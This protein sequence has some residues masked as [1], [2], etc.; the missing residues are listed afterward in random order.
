MSREKPGTDCKRFLGVHKRIPKDVRR[1]CGICRQHG[2]IVETRGH[3]CP[4]R[5][6]TCEKCSLIRERRL[7]MSTQIRLRR[8]QDRCFQRTEDAQSADLILDTQTIKTM[9]TCYVCQKC[10]NHGILKWKKDHKK[11]CVYSDCPCSQCQLIDTR[12]ALDRTIKGEK[13]A[14]RS[15]ENVS[16]K[17]LKIDENKNIESTSANLLTIPDVGELCKKIA[18]LEDTSYMKDLNTNY[19]KIPSF[20]QCNLPIHFPICSYSFSFDSPSNK[21]K[22][23]SFSIDSL[24]GN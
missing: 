24:L 22:R 21:T 9:N 19:A 2:S 18:D 15:I 10:K 11:R 13:K 8:Q 23:L 16:L 7:I 14:D 1:H 6:C 4:L 20:F 5:D 3:V 17:G 12:R